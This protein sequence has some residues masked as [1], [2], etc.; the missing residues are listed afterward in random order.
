MPKWVIVKGTRSLHVL[1]LCLDRNLDIPKDLGKSIGGPMSLHPDLSSAAVHAA[2]AD[3]HQALNIPMTS[4]GWDSSREQLKLHFSVTILG[5]LQFSSRREEPMDTRWE[6]GSCFRRMWMASVCV[7][8][9]KQTCIWRTG[10]FTRSL[11]KTPTSNPGKTTNQSHFF[12]ET[13]WKGENKFCPVLYSRSCS[14][15][16]Q[17]HQLCPLPIVLFIL[18][19]IM[20]WRYIPRLKHSR[21]NCFT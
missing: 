6:K 20:F 19:T 2:R 16:T 18:D 5:Y 9:E 15:R 8:V 12:I 10:G 11:G 17:V 21:L 7:L 1:A 4:I 14:D 13:P 3:G